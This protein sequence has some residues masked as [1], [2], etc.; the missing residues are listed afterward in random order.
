MIK[1]KD[2]VKLIETAAPR[3]LAE[4]WDNPGLAVGDENMEVKAVLTALDCDMNVVL[5]AEKKGCNMI[6]T[7]HPLLFHPLSFVTT[8]SEVGRVVLALAERKIALFSAHTNLDCAKGGTNDFLCEKLGL[9]GVEICKS[10]GE[11]NLVRIGITA[12]KTF[13]E[14][15]AELA[16]CFGKK[17]IR[18]VG[19]KNKIIEKVGICSGGGGEYISEAAGL[20][21]VYVTGDVK[22]HAARSAKEAGLCLA[23]LE[24]YESEI[25]VNEIFARILKG[26]EVPVISSE[27]NT[28]VMFDIF[29]GSEK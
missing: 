19:D 25:C 22:Y 27:A 9:G 1:V 23:V 2:I 5:E 18:C 17:Y 7:H 15:A 11:G 14:F 24:H 29:L 4:E 13:A 8:D 16:A 3:E 10:I 28:D 12:K 21:D 6:V 20:C 26:I